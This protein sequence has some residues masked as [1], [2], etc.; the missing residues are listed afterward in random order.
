MQCVP[1]RTAC[2]SKVMSCQVTSRR[3]A[4]RAVPLSANRRTPFRSRSC[5]SAKAA[6]S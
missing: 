1:I 2:G 5:G 6:L 4:R 3:T